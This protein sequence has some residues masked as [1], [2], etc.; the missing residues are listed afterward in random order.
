MSRLKPITGDK[1]LDAPILGHVRKHGAI[2]V[3]EIMQYK[4]ALASCR[5]ENEWA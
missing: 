4:E 1:E 2:S 5:M 3:I